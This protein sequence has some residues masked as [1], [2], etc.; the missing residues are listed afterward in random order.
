VVGCFAYSTGS[1]LTDPTLPLTNLKAT[2]ST[3][4][5]AYARSF[6]F[7]GKTASALVALPYT[8][9]DASAD[10]NGQR[11]SL[12][13][14]GLSDVRLRFSVLLKGAPAVTI[15][16]FGKQNHKTIIGASLN[17]VAPTGEYFSNKLINLGTHRWA[18]RPEIAL[19]QPLGKKWLIDVYTG[20]WFFTNNNKFY[21]GTASRSQEPLAA[22]QAHL[23]Y[24]I[25]LRMWAALDATYYVGGQST[26]DEKVS[27]D[28]QSNARIGAT[29]VLPVGKSS[30]LKL[31]GSTGA[32][33]RVGANF[34]TVSLGWQ[35]S[36][37]DKK[38]KMKK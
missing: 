28:R 5:L 14:S 23:S 2:V 27:D 10:I 38:Y 7:F 4:S 36:F 1:V 6:N 20:V 15:R 24:N 16:D 3:T 34:T 32:I 35:Y 18:F 25:T 26:I 12:N 29:L 31:A 21:P 30:S 17:V 13:R 9:A 19:S 22:F 11:E 8:W 37:P 33:V